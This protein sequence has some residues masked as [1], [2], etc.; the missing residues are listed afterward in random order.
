MFSQK[1]SFFKGKI[2]YVLLLGLLVF[3]YWIN[4]APETT[5]EADGISTGGKASATTQGGLST[6]G[7][8]DILDSIIG[9]TTSKGGLGADGDN[10]EATAP[11][12][13]QSKGYYLVKE[14]GGVIKVFYYDEEGK[15]KLLRTTDIAFSLLS[16]VDQD[17][18][19]R[20]VIKHSID[21]LDELLQDF[22]S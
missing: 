14:V 8:V 18:F 9:G 3:G 1:K 13:E 6:G 2:F 17:L 15:E 4:Q 7:D 11:G 21:E 19:Q 16:T 5:P 20:G 10:T 22:E 12:E